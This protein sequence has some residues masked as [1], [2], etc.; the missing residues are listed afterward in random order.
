MSL[1]TVFDF[2]EMAAALQDD[3]AI[4]AVPPTL[5]PVRRMGDSL[6]MAGTILYLASRAGSYLTGNVTLIDGGRLGLFS[7]TF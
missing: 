1:I 2:L 6:D 4:T 3:S 5:I 7:S